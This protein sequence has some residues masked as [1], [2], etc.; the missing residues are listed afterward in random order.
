M[1]RTAVRQVRD[2]LPCSRLEIDPVPA[3][4]QR[5]HHSA[6][7]PGPRDTTDVLA[8]LDPAGATGFGGV[9]RDR[10]AHDVDPEKLARPRIP[11]RAFAE[12]RGGLDRELD[13]STAP[14]FQGA[15]SSAPNPR[16][17]DLLGSP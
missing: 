8:E 16:L 17:S 10:S 4:P 13:H 9:A 11:E 14:T 6:D 1:R 2:Q 7:L 3:A 5:S 15:I 12:R